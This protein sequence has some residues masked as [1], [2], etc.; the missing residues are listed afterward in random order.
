MK[1]YRS[2]PVCSAGVDDAILLAKQVERFNRLVAQANNAA[3]ISTG[4]RVRHF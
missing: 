4:A 2:E 1:F 3:Q